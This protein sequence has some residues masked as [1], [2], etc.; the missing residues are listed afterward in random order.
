M[1]IMN[2]EFD[3]PVKEPRLIVKNLA[4]QEKI[5]S[6]DLMTVLYSAASEG[7]PTIRCPH[8]SVASFKNR[9]LVPSPLKQNG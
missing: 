1:E 4:R 8:E 3:Y 6:W 5:D 7:S 2:G 9:G